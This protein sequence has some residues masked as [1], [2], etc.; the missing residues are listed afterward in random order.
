MGENG[1]LVSDSGYFIHFTP[2]TN[3]SGCVGVK[4]KEEM[5]RLEQAFRDNALSSD[6]RALLVVKG[7][8]K[9]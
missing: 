5:A 6:N 3:T 9:K 1:E 4:T 2:Y 8:Q 7:E